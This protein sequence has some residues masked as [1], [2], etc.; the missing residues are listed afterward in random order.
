LHPD[1]ALSTLAQFEGAPSSDH[2]VHLLAATAHAE[3]L[4]SQATVDEAARGIQACDAEGAAK[5]SPADRVRFGVIS[6]SMQALVEG[7]IDPRKAP[8]QAREAVSRVLHSTKASDKSP[9][10]APKSPAP[11][12]P[13]P[14]K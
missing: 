14:K 3:R 1:W 4:E 13:A 11:N 12:T 10:A 7:N 6:Q 9:A 8:Q 5:C 2:R